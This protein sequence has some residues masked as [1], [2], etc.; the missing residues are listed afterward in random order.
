MRL[1]LVG[2]EYAGKT[3][4]GNEIT[5]WIGQT[6][7]GGRS[8]H[9]HFTIPSPELEGTDRDLVVNATPRFKEMFQ[10]YQMNYHLH[11][12]F[13]S[14]PD[15]LLTGFHIEDAVYA[16]LYYEYG[17][18]AEYAERTMLAR[19]MEREIME[20]APDTVLV[21]MKASPDVIAR[22]MKES[23]HSPGLVQEKDI[24]HVLERF[25]EEYSRT[26][27]RRKF[28]L[29]TTTATVQ[30]TLAE[31]GEKVMPTLTDRDRLRLLVHQARERGG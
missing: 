9:D 29:D 14:D 26:L 13:Y 3:T 1:I 22:R 6:L 11:P 31:F 5:G 17:G 20:V 7:G 10:R 27:L 4:L 30:E 18:P 12:S 8:F 2:C 21:L 28:E 16:P 25:E 23:P 19:A 15:H 24:E